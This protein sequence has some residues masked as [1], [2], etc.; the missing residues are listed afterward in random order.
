MNK[1]LVTAL[2]A[3]L[4]VAPLIAYVPKAQAQPYEWK[5]IYIKLVDQLGNPIRCAEVIVILWNASV[6]HGAWDSTNKTECLLLFT[7]TSTDANGTLTLKLN[8]PDSAL[9]SD[10]AGLY[11]FTIIL[12]KDIGGTTYYFLL[13]WT[14]DS[15]PDGVPASVLT[16]Y[17]NT[18]ANIPGIITCYHYWN[19]NFTVL[20]NCTPDHIPLY[21]E[22][23]NTGKVDK[24]LVKVYFPDKDGTKVF[25]EYIDSNGYTPYFNFS[26]TRVE[27]AADQCHIKNLYNV[28]L[29]KEV[30]WSWGNILVTKD[31]LQFVSY[32]ANSSWPLGWEPFRHDSV[33]TVG[34]APWYNVTTY[35]GPNLYVN[36][37]ILTED[38]N[39]TTTLPS[40]TNDVNMTVRLDS[41]LTVVDYAY[42]AMLN[43][44]LTD[45]C[46][47]PIAGTTLIKVAL[48]YGDTVVREAQTTND[49]VPLPNYGYEYPSGSGNWYLWVPDVETVYGGKYTLKVVAENVGGGVRI[50]IFVDYI[51]YPTNCSKIG[52]TLGI[53]TSLVP[54][55]IKVV[56][57][58]EPA[59]PLVN[60]PFGGIE[61]KIV[62]K[63][64]WGELETTTA[65]YAGYRGYVLLPPA[66][67]LPTPAPWSALY[68]YGY[69]V[70]PYGASSATYE[71]KV[72]FKATHGAEFVDVTD[73]NN[74]TIKV[75]IDD[76]HKNYIV[77]AKVYQAKI[78]LLS[79]CDE[80]LSSKDYPDAKVEIYTE[81][82]LKIAE[83]HS[84]PEDGTVFIPKL[85]AGVYKLKLYWK[86]RELEPTD[87]KVLNVTDN[88]RIAETFTFPV[89][90]LAFQLLSWNP[91][92]GKEGVTDETIGLIDGYQAISGL[93][94]TIIYGCDYNEPWQISN[95]TGWVEFK[96]VP[97]GL[98][99]TLVVYTNQTPFTRREGKFDDNI[100]VY[101]KNITV[102]VEPCTYIEKVHVWIYSFYMQ[103]ETCEGEVLKSFKVNGTAWYNV[104]VVICD[105]TW[106]KEPP[107]CVEPTLPSCPTCA[108]QAGEITVDFRIM[109][110]SYAKPYLQRVG[111]PADI[112]TTEPEAKFLI[113]SAQWDPAHP[114]LFVAG[115]R[116]TVKVFYGGTLV[117]NYTF[118]LPRPDKDVT[119]IFNET[120]RLI[121][122]LVNTAEWDEYPDGAIKVVEEYDY[123]DDYN[124]LYHPILTVKGV[125]VGEYPVIELRTWVIP[126]RVWTWTK[127]YALEACGIT[128]DHEPYL[129]PGLRIYLNYSRV[130]NNT[131]TVDYTLYSAICDDA[132]TGWTEAIYNVSATDVDLN[133]YVTFNVPVWV[134]RTAAAKHFNGISFGNKITGVRVYAVGGI[135]PGIPGDKEEVGP[136]NEYYD[137]DN[138]EWVHWNDTK[139]INPV[140]YFPPWNVSAINEECV[141][142]TV[143]EEG[144]PQYE[145]T[146]TGYEKVPTYEEVKHVLCAG[147]TWCGVE[148]NVSTSCLEC[149]AVQIYGYDVCGEKTP[150]AYQK[151]T[152]EVNIAGA[153]LTVAS[154]TK[155]TTDPIKFEPTTVEVSTPFGTVKKIVEGETLPVFAYIG[156][157]YTIKATHDIAAKLKDL[158]YSPDLA[159]KFCPEVYLSTTIEF[160][161]DHNCGKTPIEYGWKAILIDLK[162]IANVK[163]LSNMAVVAVKV[164]TNAP[165][166][167]DITD[168]DGKAV[169]LVD[170]GTYIVQVY[171]KD[172]LFIE[173]PIKIFDSFTDQPNAFING[174]VDMKSE[175]PVTTK[176]IE[177]YVYALRLRLV[178]ADGKTPLKKD[179]IWV[180]VE[181]PDG[182]K[183]IHDFCG[184]C[185]AGIA[186]NKDT[187]LE[188][189]S[190]LTLEDNP[191]SCSRVPIGTYKVTV[192]YIASAKEGEY[193]KA[194]EAIEAGKVVVIGSDTV[195]V[196]KMRLGTASKV[197]DIKC[198]VYD[199][200]VTVVTPW[201]TPL[202]GAKVKVEVPAT[203]ETIEG[204]L[205]ET[206]SITLTDIAKGE[207]KITVTEW[208]N[209][210]VNWET[211]VIYT[212]PK[213]VCSNIGKLVIKTVGARGQP[214]DAAVAIKGVTTATAK[215]GVLEVE[216]PAGSYE[217]TVEY[218]GKKVTETLTVEAGKVTEKTFQLD[219]FIQLAGWPMTLPEFFGFILLIVFIIIALF[220]LMHEY[221]VWRRKRLAKALVQAKPAK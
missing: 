174:V 114:H 168:K 186:E 204:T 120:Y 31:S 109:N 211:T 220:L 111:L 7:R 56:D 49:T 18:S 90:N 13:N 162:D 68:P 164:G 199:F 148:K 4:L 212:A 154:G 134:P 208:K 88:I 197:V 91:V 45:A 44:T 136:I 32:V 210:A 33:I 217:V 180:V 71:I 207:V 196:E 122:S 218:G 101:E 160:T 115:A 42:T 170:E 192:Y 175:G 112:A 52:Y 73:P 70:V 171:W 157:A 63:G 107:Y 159:D 144:T 43:F 194:K 156:K 147:P 27:L 125:E 149:F 98:N 89:R 163:P 83:V 80:P 1:I 117:Y 104:T 102:P 141:T 79:L 14:Y 116:Y 131:F 20:D 23:P 30:Y 127:S 54:I 152:V 138:E 137:C 19:F 142:V 50:P 133:G 205:D 64:P 41:D 2:L 166:I 36:D 150:V 84:I 132:E 94:A 123:E 100:L 118:K 173:T 69:V 55:S 95:C 190:K 139:V 74:S 161:N 53:K 92:P 62:V 34:T 26:D 209:V 179:N 128:P 140:Y 165:A 58:E 6:N 17:F 61:V 214:L 99:V 130:L 81:D 75:T 191:E 188:L 143:L 105:T 153:T 124:W 167:F 28:T 37:L 172:T 78:K 10:S 177:A 183:T 65:D 206:G 201:G 185:I 86:C 85:P 200:T 48:E 121:P 39:P 22:D 5:A 51:S 77:I 9:R 135:T 59:Q 178:K 126:L 158:G 24:A 187:R 129:I 202:A 184:K 169:L 87:G 21:Y 110:V 182:T 213:V 219:I 198:D 11:N 151:I 215:E 113:T 145:C 72:Y 57:S 155:K 108:P 119:Y 25:E 203:G 193:A 93:N 76:C 221:S 29:Y 216:L 8:L 60:D 16:S 189:T 47:N 146:P 82:G 66:K 40:N 181:W 12:V 35:L 3:A 38:F 103:A 106:Q 195:T 176:T 96:K 67:P 15:Y 97:V 46:E